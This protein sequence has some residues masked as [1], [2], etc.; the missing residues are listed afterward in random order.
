MYILYVW[1][2]ICALFIVS[3]WS[4]D[5]TKAGSVCDFKSV[6]FHKWKMLKTLAESEQQSEIYSPVSDLCVPH[7]S[8]CLYA[9]TVNNNLLYRIKVFAFHKSPVSILLV[10]L[11]P[12]CLFII[13]WGLTFLISGGFLGSLHGWGNPRK[14]HCVQCETLKNKKLRGYGKSYLM[15]FIYLAHLNKHKG[16]QSVAQ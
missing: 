11:P 13:W 5:A 15:H 6:C 4:E 16:P 10:V 1:G 7:A 9:L 2:H 8:V 12:H 14:G 3:C